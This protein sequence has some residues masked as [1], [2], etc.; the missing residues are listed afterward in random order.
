MPRL[1]LKNKKEVAKVTEPVVSEPIEDDLFDD[2][3]SE[4][5]AEPVKVR[6]PK[7]A[8][9]KTFEQTD[10]IPCHSVTQGGLYVEGSK[11]RVLYTFSNYGDETEIEYRDLV[12]F[13]NAKSEF[14]FH[15][16]F[17]IDDPD[18]IAEFPQLEKFYAESYDV[19]DLGAILKL[20]VNQMIEKIKQLPKGA[21][22]NIKI[23]ASAQVSD[24]RLDSVK[25]I[26]EL[27][28]FFG[29]DLNLIAELSDN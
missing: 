19:K 21:A 2:E 11:T 1:S 16:D 26:K 27:N 12:G 24:G 22:E 23:L 4:P 25:K 29:I 5:V 17:I 10:R 20:P 18:F 6:K 15:P 7:A 3:E 14:I 28:E 13:I 8:A 9:K